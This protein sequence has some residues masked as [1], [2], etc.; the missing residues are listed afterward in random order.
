MRVP[1][2]HGGQKRASD[3]LK[4][5]ID[6]CELTWELGLKPGSPARATSALNN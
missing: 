5:S 2:A 4:W 3:S 6:G 1:C